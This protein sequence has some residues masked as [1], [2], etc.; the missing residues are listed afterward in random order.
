MY[1]WTPVVT[2]YD[3]KYKFKLAMSELIKSQKASD[4]P[5]CEGPKLRF[6][7][8]RHQLD[9]VRRFNSKRG[10]L[11][12]WCNSC[13]HWSDI[14]EVNLDISNSLSEQEL[15]KITDYNFVES[16]NKRWE[17]KLIPDFSELRKSD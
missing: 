15:D 3:P 8:H 6:F 10:T 12:M 4:C 9:L 1:K 7:Y 17:K 14:S 11:W 16:L 13:F 2:S 5:W